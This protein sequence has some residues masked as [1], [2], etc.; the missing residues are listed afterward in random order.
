MSNAE[1]YLQ[2]NFLPTLTN[3][4]FNDDKDFAYYRDQRL[5]LFKLL[6]VPVGYFS[7]CSYL[8]IGPDSGENALFAATLGA[9]LTCVDPNPLSNTKVKELFDSYRGGILMSKLVSNQMIY[10]EN[11][12]SKTKFSFV[13]CEGML[14]TVKNKEGFYEKLASVV[15][16]HGFLMISYY[17]DLSIF[18]DLFQSKI[19]KDIIYNQLETQSISES[20]ILEVKKIG[21]DL[22]RNKWSRIRHLRSLDTWVMDVL[23]NPVIRFENGVDVITL[24]EKFQSLGLSYWNSWPRYEKTSDMRW[25]RKIQNLDDQLNVIALEHKKM[26]L[27]FLLGYSTDFMHAIDNSIVLNEIEVLCKDINQTLD[28]SDWPSLKI[29][30]GSLLSLLYSNPCFVQTQDFKK[31]ISIV[32]MLLFIIDL[33]IEKKYSELIEVIKL[34]LVPSQSTFDFGNY[35]GQP[36]HYLALYKDC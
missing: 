36:N 25:H 9:E 27:Q 21:V 19:F 22:F 11:F 8:E 7:N 6:K 17:S 16:E 24:L 3:I 35:W 32:K 4:D 20:N 1:F 23:I 26:S 31:I 33:L 29:Q 34:E 30:F 15:R 14:S 5:Y 12:D 13:A 28:K 18:S 2:N 10:F